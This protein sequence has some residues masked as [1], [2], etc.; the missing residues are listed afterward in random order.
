[1]SDPSPSS[2]EQS[3]SGISAALQH[4]KPYV[5]ASESPAEATFRALILGSILG[6]IFG[7]ASVYL[8]LRVGLTT[9]ASIPIAV[10]S[11]TILKKLGKSTILEN[12]IVQTVGSAGE[13]IAAAVVFTVPALIFLGYALSASLTLLIA[14]TG[15]V[16]G[17]LMM[18]PLRRY[19]IVKEHGNLRFPEGTACAEILKAGETGGT[20]AA[21]IFKGM[22]IGAIFKIMP[23]LFG[24]WKPT[25]SADI[26]TYPGASIGMDVSPELMGVGYIIGWQTSVIM[27]A[28][29]LLSSFI[30]GPII[31][32][33]GKSATEAIYPATKL[34]SQMSPYEIWRSYIKYIGAGAVATGGI[35]GLF[36]ALPAIWDSLRASVKQL[37]K[38]RFGNG[39]HS[40]IERTERDTPITVVAFGSLA[41]VFFIWLVPTFRMNL[42]GAG[43]I[44]LFGFLFSVVSARITGIVGSSSS[45]LSGMTIAVLMGTCLIFLAVGW[46]GSSYTYLALVIGAVVCI[47]IS[48]AGTTAQDLK[49]G[50]L[51]GSTPRAQQLGLLIGVVTSASVVGY[52]MILLNTSQTKE[53]ALDKPFAPP[54]AAL[55]HAEPI[56]ARDGKSYLLAKVSGVEGVEPGN[57]LVDQQSG[58]AVKRRIDGIGGRELAAPQANLMAVLIGG[59]LEQKLPWGLIMIGVCIALF[60]EL[61][62]MHSLTFAVGVYLPLSST[63]PIFVGG[64]VRKI[65]DKVYKRKADD[66]EESEGTLLSSGLI[67]GGALIGVLGAFLHFVTPFDDDDTGLPLNLAFGYKAFRFLWDMDFL[68]VAMFALLAYLVLRGA[69]GGVRLQS[70]N[71]S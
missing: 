27:V 20:S 19:L 42:L 8:G 62:G 57:Y 5:P 22:G 24:F 28:G 66:M 9:S 35:V 43:L 52:T 3:S 30:I 32:F 41:L 58:I 64:L 23:T 40:L 34:I 54:A 61:M 48:N 38:E 21:K 10:M 25:P 4:F 69:R 59:L 29:G 18:I 51:V 50:F 60:I 33:A 2:A 67:A 45:P 1:M 56:E 68:S 13:S 46:G 14:L 65:A 12:N 53:V 17:V 55:Q 70:G 49:T 16:L 44:V 37:T 39:G 11:I 7:A 63:L 47:A 26:A 71:E 31:A 6:I 36:R 15:G